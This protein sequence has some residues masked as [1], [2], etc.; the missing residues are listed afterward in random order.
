MTELGWMTELA[1]ARIVLN[2]TQGPSASHGMTELAVMETK[3]KHASLGMTELAWVT[4][5]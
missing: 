4:E 1:S 2:Q 5:S 3:A